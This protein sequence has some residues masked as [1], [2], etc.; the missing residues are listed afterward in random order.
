MNIEAQD[1]YVRTALI[2]ARREAHSPIV[3]VVCERGAK[4]ETQDDEGL[5]TLL[6][7]TKN[8][9]ISTFQTLC[10]LGANI[11]IFAQIPNGKGL[12]ALM[13][14]REL[15]NAH[16]MQVLCAPG[17]NVNAQH[18]K[19]Y[20]ALMHARKLFEQSYPRCSAAVLSGCSSLGSDNGWCHCM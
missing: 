7:A 16:M 13:I 18:N 9:H 6:H 17:V 8:A 15:D 19:G 1:N 4:I 3:N 2:H 10:D 5:N 14:A 11:D 12:S 20:S